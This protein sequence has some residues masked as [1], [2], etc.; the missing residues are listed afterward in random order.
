MR[1]EITKQEIDSYRKQ[2]FVVLAGMFDAAE[3]AAWREAV[4]EAVAA[5][6][7]S[8]LANADWQSGDS[9]YDK[10]FIQRLNLWQDSLKVR[11]LILDSRIGKI[12]CDLEG[13][14]GMRIWHDQAL[15]KMPWANPTSWHLDDPYWSFSSPHATSIW[16]ALDDATLENGCMFF[17]PGAHKHGRFDNVGIGDSMPDIFKAFPEYKEVRAVAAPM[18][19]GSCSFH[20]GLLIH[21]ANANMT[22]GWRRAMTCGFMPDGSTFNGKSNILSKE[23][24][25][26]LKIGD[27]LE[28]N[29]Q[30]P[31][32]FSRTKDYRAGLDALIAE[33]ATIRA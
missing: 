29:R 23:Q 21:G 2:G 22:P 18:K 20:N 3:L 30:N 31:L 25:A 13:V 19:A 11:K 15:I 28:D 27:V 33:E 26:K 12:A 32:V 14:D 17:I 24:I 1:T 4:D 6:E 16:I 5:R 7:N 9:Y 8:K 10:V